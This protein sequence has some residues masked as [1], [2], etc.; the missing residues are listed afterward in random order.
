MRKKNK[1]QLLTKEQDKRLTRYMNLINKIDKFIDKKNSAIG[2]K[3]NWEFILEGLISAYINDP[4]VTE[5]GQKRSK[6]WLKQLTK[7]LTS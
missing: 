5:L 7:E 1:K 3:F 4:D 2:Y 6:K